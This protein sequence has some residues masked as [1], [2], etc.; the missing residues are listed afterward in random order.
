MKL[1]HR[2]VKTGYLEGLRP[3]LVVGLAETFYTFRYRV[4]RSGE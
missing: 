1:P 3:H 4:R 2:R